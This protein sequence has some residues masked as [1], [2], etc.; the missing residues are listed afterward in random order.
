MME[1]A[2]VRAPQAFNVLDVTARLVLR[3]VCRSA[4]VRLHSAT[5]D[6]VLDESP[7]REGVSASSQL[8]VSFHPRP[9]DACSVS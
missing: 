9:T 8:E 5:L 1:L 7:L 2:V 3:A 6:T 4:H